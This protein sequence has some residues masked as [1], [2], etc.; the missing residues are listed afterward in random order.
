MFT[1]AVCQVWNGNADH[2]HANI[3][4]VWPDLFLPSILYA[5]VIGW[6]PMTSAYKMEGKNSLV[7]RL[8]QSKGGRKGL[9]TLSRM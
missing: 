4:L 8:V 2:L 9:V 5:A 7:P 6:G 1:F 3:S